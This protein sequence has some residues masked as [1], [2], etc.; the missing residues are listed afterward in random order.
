VTVCLYKT[1]P[2]SDLHHPF[3]LHGYDFYVMAVDQFRN[4]DSPESMSDKLF[5][6][7]FK[8]Q[9]LP[10][11]KDTIAVPSGG[12]AAVRFKADNPGKTTC[13]LTGG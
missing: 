8:R 9:S 6:S 13:T 1:A 11:R 10:A 7:N 4:G 5:N 12:Y 3:H 2:A